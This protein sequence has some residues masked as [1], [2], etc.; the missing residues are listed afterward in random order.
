MLKEVLSRVTTGV[1]SAESFDANVEA[2]LGTGELLTAAKNDM[3]GTNPEPFFG[4]ER[5]SGEPSFFQELTDSFCAVVEKR[6]QL[7]TLMRYLTTEIVEI[8]NNSYAT[9]CGYDLIL[10]D[11]LQEIK[12]DPE[13]FSVLKEFK[14]F[15]NNEEL[16]IMGVGGEVQ[17]IRK[18]KKSAEYKERLLRLLNSDGSRA[19][20][21]DSDSDAYRESCEL[22]VFWIAGV[23][24]KS[25]VL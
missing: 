11:F 24:R 5:Q 21:E 18:E 10:F 2:L 14:C 8:T 4:I 9:A 16:Q 20:S 1:T 6:Q 25:S 13:L 15:P 17:A 22:L 23:T 3:E 7:M 19:S 12:S